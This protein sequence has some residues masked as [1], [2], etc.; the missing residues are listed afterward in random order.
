MIYQV[1]V[2]GEEGDNGEV[3]SFHLVSFSFFLYFLL[4]VSLLGVA[5]FER[6]RFIGAA[7]PLPAFAIISI[8]HLI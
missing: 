7:S 1:R 3:L 6:D 2:D 8:Q 4:I 5:G